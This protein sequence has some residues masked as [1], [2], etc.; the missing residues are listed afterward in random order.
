MTV[1]ELLLFTTGRRSRLFD[2]RT[3]LSYGRSNNHIDFDDDD[4]DLSDGD[5]TI[6]EIKNADCYSSRNGEVYLLGGLS[7]TQNEDGQRNEFVCKFWKLNPVS[8]AWVAQS[9]LPLPRY[10]SA[11][12]EMNNKIYVMGGKSIKEGKCLSKVHIFDPITNSWEEGPEM[13]RKVYGHS[14]ASLKNEKIFIIGGETQSRVILSDVY[15]LNG[16]TNN[17]HIISSLNTP[18]FLAS[19]ATSPEEDKIYVL[20]GI[21]P[22][23][24]LSSMEMIS[25][26]KLSSRWKFLESF[27]EARCA[28]TIAF[29]DGKL[30]SYGGYVPNRGDKDA[31]TFRRDFYMF[32]NDRWVKKI[33][34]VKCV[35]RNVHSTCVKVQI[36]LCQIGFEF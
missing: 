5:V 31:S 6:P 36:S 8:L 26:P 29:F 35:S 14:C 25:S 18:R 28:Q 24:L 27:P 20:G 22:S 17:W 33:N 34:E 12:G 10:M 21:G 23:G 11:F 13:I 7:L 19:I 1:N 32:S 16:D 9:S 15:C 30:C 3:S 2:P 4:D